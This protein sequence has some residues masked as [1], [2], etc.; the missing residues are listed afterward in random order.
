MISA[1]ELIH[2]NAYKVEVMNESL[3]DFKVE[4]AGKMVKKGW[5]FRNASKK[6]VVR[7]QKVCKK[8]YV[9]FSGKQF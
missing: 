9:S 2:A 7:P 8:C 4:A 6:Q 5:W 3:T 1:S